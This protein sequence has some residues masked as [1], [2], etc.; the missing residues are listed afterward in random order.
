MKR[1][2]NIAGVLIVVSMLSGCCVAHEWEDAT[3]VTPKTCSTCEKT[4][5]EALGHKWEEATCA[6][7]KHCTVCGITEGEVLEHQWIVADYENPKM[8]TVCGE[9]EGEKLKTFVEEHGI[10]VNR[11]VGKEYIYE[12]VTS[13][14]NTDVESVKGKLTLTNKEFV[15]GKERYEAEEGYKWCILNAQMIF[16]GIEYPAAR[17]K[18]VNLA[19]RWI[20][21]KSGKRNFVK[22]IVDNENGTT[23][24]LWNIDGKEVPITVTIELDSEWQ[25]GILN[26]WY[27]CGIKV[28][29]D[30]DDLVFCFTNA[31]LWNSDND[32][33][34]FEKINDE[35][36]IAL[37]I[38]E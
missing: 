8:C 2:L 4:E 23:V 19:Y 3:C 32:V 17:K 21:A 20:D 13:T 10:N 35:N 5:G 16:D 33:I 12:T 9:T 18:G 1:I 6:K 14:D 22:R 31:L 27:E 29:K 30:Y 11:E 24:E 25:N 34:D 37:S 28:P 36:M 7:A 38:N 15:E 26:I